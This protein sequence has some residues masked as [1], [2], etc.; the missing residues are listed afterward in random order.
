MLIKKEICGRIGTRFECRVSVFVLRS[1]PYYIM[2]IRSFRIMVCWLHFHDPCI[3]RSNFN[4]FSLMRIESIFNN[5]AC[6]FHPMTKIN[7][8]TSI[9]CVFCIILSLTPCNARSRTAI[10]SFQSHY[11]HLDSIAECITSYVPLEEAQKNAVNS[12]VCVILGI[13]FEYL[14]LS[15]LACC[16]S[17]WIERYPWIWHYW[18][19]LLYYWWK[20]EKEVRTKRS[21][22]EIS[23]II[24]V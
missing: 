5:S 18:I 14:C 16:W 3:K 11:H 6:R 24:V 12:A 9:S 15:W 8:D 2:T 21:L 1:L 22:R 13:M 23:I 7:A 19:L 4:D 10:A 17:W 20:D